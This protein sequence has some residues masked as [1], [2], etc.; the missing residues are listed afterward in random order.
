MPSLLRP[1][2]W[3]LLPLLFAG[4]A[5]YSTVQKNQRTADL[6]TTESQR[7]LVAMQR[8]LRDQPR[9]QIGAGLDAANAARL[10]LATDPRNAALQSDYNFAV[11]R[12]LDLV[13]REK[14][15]PSV[16]PVACPSPVQGIWNLTLRAPSTQPGLDASNFTFTPADRFSFRGKGVGERVLKPGLGA[17]VIATGKDRD[18]RAIDQFAQGRHIYYG[19]TAVIRFRGRE[20]EIV[21]TDPLARETVTLDGTTY[22]LA[23][24]FVAPLSLALAELEP[25]KQEIRGLFKPQEFQGAARLARLEPFD[26]DKTPVLLIHGLGNSPAIWAPLIE[27]LR[28]DRSIRRNYQFWF[29]AYPSGLPYPLSAA[30][31]RRQLALIRKEYPQQK[32]AVVIGHSMGGM[33]SRLMLTDSGNKLWDAFFDVPPKRIPL[34]PA[35][36]RTLVDSLVFEPVPKISR[37]IFVSASHRGSKMATDFWGRVANTLVGNPIAD[38]NVYTEAIPYA[39]PT[40][41]ARSL[42]RLPNSIDLLAPDNAFVTMI[43]A[44]PLERGVPYHSV[45]GDRGRGG[46]LG[47]TPLPVSSDGVVPYW[48]SH[49]DGARSEKIVPSNHWAHLHPEGMAE[50]KRILLENLRR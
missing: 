15:Q 4:C 22:P 3:F 42:K 44:L 47:R 24:D 46:T 50:I 16:R 34:S 23:A 10:R 25:K 27:A 40:A 43:D 8:R 7:S 29:Y 28:A 32:D 37:V 11:A 26:P 9:E 33:I 45:M 20:A 18:Y 19:L 14:L 21:F 36:R 12:V 39:R 5:Q 2:L 35:S 41:K 49:L 30:E 17:P 38:Q 31:L 6:A 13:C 1:P 48:S